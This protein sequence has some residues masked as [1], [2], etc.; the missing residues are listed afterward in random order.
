MR[1]LFR[2][3][4]RGGMRKQFRRLK[5]PKH[6]IFLIVGG[7]AAVSWISMVFVNAMA[8]RQISSVGPDVF[9]VTQISMFVLFVLTIVGA[10]SYRG[11]YLPKD[12]I[13]LGFSAPITRSE[14]VRYRLFVSM[15]KSLFAGLLFGI[16]AAVRTS[17][18]YAFCGVFVGMMTIPIVGQGAALLLGGAESR[19]GRLAKYFPGRVLVRIGFVLFVVL[20]VMYANGSL[21]DHEE[22]F[23]SGTGTGTWTLD[24]F[25]SHPLVRA[26]LLPFTPWARIITAQSFA[27]FA[28]Y[29]LFAVGIWFFLF[30]SVARIG[31]DYREL[32]LATSA[33]VAKRISRMR[34]GNL[35][36]TRGNVTRATIGWRVP[37]LFGRGP[38]GAVAWNKTASIVRK[39][40]GTLLIS[41]GIIT[42]LTILGTA[43]TRDRDAE[44]ML[45]HGSYLIAGVGTL[46]MCAGLRFDF[47]MD[48]DIMD[49]VKTWPLRPSLLFLATILPE[50]VLVSGMLFLA[51][52]GR[53][54]WIGVYHPALIGVLAFQPI[55]TLT[56]V[57]LDNA[58][59]LFSP[60]RYTPGEE[61]ALQNMG[62]SM[63]LVILR[64]VLGG[65]IALFVL[66]PAYGVHWLVEE[67]G[68][69]DSAWWW[70]SAIAWVLALA[71]D[72]ALIW[73]G[74]RM[75]TRFDVAK[76]RPL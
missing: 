65:I 45:L 49:R 39:S 19:I 23:E 7:L 8:G 48:L 14:L 32:S 76:D 41:G 15:M 52:L 60:I 2:L 44:K 50:V 16:G 72:A 69:G 47:R 46:Y 62:R 71:V 22:L 24:R 13:E 40:R 12:E 18:V 70:A 67:Q 4:F 6:W 9:V 11:L 75:L 53:A 57:A 51:V 42:F 31:V 61:G 21:G 66:L 73:L 26:L 55:A 3:K 27:E 5:Q 59:F 43:I 63:L 29:F 74:G 20:A 37:W 56:W 10:L 54:L 58:V 17:S 28:P 34:K 33:D 35:D 1:L 64:G 30:E 36:P 38:F 68:G 25:A